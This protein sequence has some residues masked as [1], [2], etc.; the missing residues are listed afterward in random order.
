VHCQ[1]TLEA[2][3]LLQQ[4][5]REFRPEQV[6]RYLARE[7]IAALPNAAAID[8]SQF[9]GLSDADAAA[10]AASDEQANQY[11]EL[12]AALQS[13]PASAPLRPY[14]VSVVGRWTELEATSVAVPASAAQPGATP[15]TPLAGQRREFDLEDGDGRR[16]VVL[17]AVVPGRR[18][19]V[20]KGEGCDIRVN[21]TYA[22]RRHAEVWLDADGS[23]WVGDVGST[24]GIRVESPGGAQAQRGP[25]GSDTDTRPIRLEQ[26]AR[27]VLSARAQGPASEYPWLALRVPAAAPARLTPV[28]TAAALSDVPKTP[29]TAILSVAPA[30]NVLTITSSDGGAARTLPLHPGSLPATVGRS[31]NQALVIDWRHDVVS[32]HHLAI[33]DI[34]EASV[35]GVVHGDNGVL[36]GG[37]AYPPG[38]H[39]HWKVG[40][41]MALGTQPGEDP[42]CTLS[43]GRGSWPA[44]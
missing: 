20:G 24:N 10:E 26:G 29:L 32:G 36:I 37:V 41:T 31:R 14:Q 27:V 28:A 2:H 17:Q 40:E 13:T 44:H 15:S 39:F 42:T 6:K 35:R 4:F 38:A 11:G 33:T 7:V 22:S 25:A 3:Q 9:A 18:Y 1:G 5:T 16:H 30:E 21:G 23:W 19:V 43:L 34:D 12:L 8:L